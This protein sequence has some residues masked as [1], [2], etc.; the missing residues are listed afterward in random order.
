MTYGTTSDYKNILKESTFK[1]KG[2]FKFVVP[3]RSPARV[4]TY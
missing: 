3:D 2:R 4:I 1:E